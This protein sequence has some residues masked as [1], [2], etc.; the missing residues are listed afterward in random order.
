MQG[1]LI[2]AW[3]QSSHPTVEK[4]CEKWVVSVDGIETETGK[5]KPRQIGTFNSRRAAQCRT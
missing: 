1:G 5:H 2:V 4:R 3:T